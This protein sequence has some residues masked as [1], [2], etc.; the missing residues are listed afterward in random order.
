ML[1]YTETQLENTYNIYRLHQAK[2][3][4]P[5]ITLENFR[6]MFEEIFQEIYKEVY[7]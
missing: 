2:H 5:F 4:L 3:D 1:L 6:Y 7:E